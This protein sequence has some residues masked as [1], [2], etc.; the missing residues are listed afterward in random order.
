M[1]YSTPKGQPGT[2]P[3]QDQCAQELERLPPLHP[4]TGYVPYLRFLEYCI[5]P[6]GNLT[7]LIDRNREVSLRETS[8]SV[9]ANNVGAIPRL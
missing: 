8:E 3:Y 1:S 5:Q 7:A 6:H 2:T 4:P 9:R